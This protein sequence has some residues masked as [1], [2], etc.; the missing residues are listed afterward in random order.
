MK[1]RRSPA[2]GLTFRPL[3]L[4]TAQWVERLVTE[5][6]GSPRVVSRGVLHQVRELPGLIA[7]REGKQV[8]LVQYHIAEH[9]FEIVTLVAQERRTGIGRALLTAAEPIARAAGCNR[10]WLGFSFN[11]FRNNQFV[12]Q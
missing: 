7:L 9:D 2:A 3:T 11:K 1:T 12:C 6:F 5:H 4:Y 8:G 10:M